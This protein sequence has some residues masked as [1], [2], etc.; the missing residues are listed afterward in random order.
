MIKKATIN[1]KNTNDN[2]CFAY[3]ATIAIYHEEIGKNLDR[4][5]SKLILVNLIGLT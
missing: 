1:P 3:Y 5:S 2:Y 4:I